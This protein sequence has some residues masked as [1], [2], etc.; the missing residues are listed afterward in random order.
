MGG[1]ARRGRRSTPPNRREGFVDPADR[2]GI[3]AIR[4]AF[5]IAG[6]VAVV[7]GA[8]SGLG[9]ASAVWLGGAGATVVVNHLPASPDAAAAVCREIEEVGGEAVAFEAAVRDPE[10]VAEMFATAVE[11]CGPVTTLVHNARPQ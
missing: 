7:T 9:R 2:E 3:A 11:R 6:Q 10:Q 4:K 8:S 1:G 5:G